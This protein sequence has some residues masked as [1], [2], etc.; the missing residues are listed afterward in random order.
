MTSQRRAARVLLR[1]HL[2]TIMAAFAT[3]NP[4]DLHDWMQLI[5]AE[6]L[7]IPG[8]ALTKQQAQRLWGLPPNVCDS[9]LDSMIETHFLRRIHGDSFVRA[10]ICR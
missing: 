10:D 7:E 6:Y 9:V 4:V 8:L 3:D 1:F 2:S 5:R